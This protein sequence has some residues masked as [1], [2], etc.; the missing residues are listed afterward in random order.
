MNFVKASVKFFASLTFCSIIRLA[1]GGSEGFFEDFQYFQ[2]VT[3]KSKH[4][5]LSQLHK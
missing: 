5:A 1:G 4:R 3:G 2:V